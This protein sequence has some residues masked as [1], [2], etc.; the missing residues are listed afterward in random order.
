MPSLHQVGGQN[1]G[2]GRFVKSAS[3]GQRFTVLPR[4][5][6]R[7]RPIQDALFQIKFQVIG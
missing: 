3:I 6:R 1:L 5:G 2:S 4:E 7:G